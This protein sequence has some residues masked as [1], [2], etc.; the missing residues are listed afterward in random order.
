ML[1]DFYTGTLTRGNTARGQ[2]ICCI[3]PVA[4]CAENDSIVES[5]KLIQRKWITKWILS[6]LMDLT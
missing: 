2:A 6:H 4:V 3:S 1:Y 5:Y